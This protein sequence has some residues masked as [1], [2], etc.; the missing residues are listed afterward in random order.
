VSRAE[1]VMTLITPLT[2][3]APQSVA[4]GP[5]MTSTVSM[6]STSTSCWSQNT[7]ENSGV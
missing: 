3:F 5:L 7:P 6:S 1:R 4:R 2:A